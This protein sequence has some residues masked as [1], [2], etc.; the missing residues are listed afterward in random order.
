[1]AHSNKRTRKGRRGG[2]RRRHRG[3]GGGAGE[4][5]RILGMVGGV[6]GRRDRLSRRKSMSIIRSRSRGEPTTRE[7]RVILVVVVVVVVVTSRAFSGTGTKRG[8]TREE[9]RSA[10][11]GIQWLF[12]FDFTRTESPRA[13]GERRGEE[14][15]R[16]EGFE[17]ARVQQKRGGVGDGDTLG[18][19]GTVG[20]EK[21]TKNNHTKHQLF[22]L[23]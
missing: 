23:V 1:M 20:R 19:G 18:G 14:E 5:E 21:E 15:V 9:R 3:S 17:T 2:G 4:S 10:S 13:R 16:R 22:Q 8:T 6:G 7:T 11:F 12:D